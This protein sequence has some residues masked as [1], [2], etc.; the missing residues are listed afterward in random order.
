MKY[1]VY[2]RTFYKYTSRVSSCH[3]LAC[4]QPSHFWDQDIRNESLSILPKPSFIKSYKDSFNN[5]RSYFSIPEEHDELEIISEFTVYLKEKNY[6]IP[7]LTPTWREVAANSLKPESS[8][9]V[10][11][12]EF[13]Y[14][15][16][17]TIANSEIHQYA[18]DSF[19]DDKTLLDA[20]CELM[21]RM[22]TDFTFDNSATEVE[23]KPQ[24][25]IKN[26]RG[27]CQDFAHFFISCMR[28]MSIPAKY[29]SGYILTH[30]AEGSNKLFGADASHAWVSIFCPFFGW[31]D[32]DPTNN[33]I[34]GLEHIRIAEGRDYHDIPPVKGV[35]TGNGAHTLDISVDVSPV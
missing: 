3:N 17:Y 12:N 9:S 7:A 11:A 26:K 25:L 34:N 6:P 27:V 30:P 14:P 15:T 33:I 24:T 13:L 4:L 35:F 20:A 21:N 32:L 16:P 28:A 23:S 29:V 10:K 22:F 5:R 31:I 19:G 2:H 8:E 1:K 18:K